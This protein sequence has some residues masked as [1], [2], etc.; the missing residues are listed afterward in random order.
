MRI[1]FCGDSIIE[2]GENKK[3]GF[4]RLLRK[5]FENIEILNAG[6]SGNTVMD[7]LRRLRKDVLRKNP[8]EVYLLIGINDVWLRKRGIGTS[9]NNF[10][11]YYNKLIDKLE[12]KG[13]KINICTLT[14]LGELEFKK[15][16]YDEILYDFIEKI[17]DISLERK[18][19]LIDVNEIFQKYYQMN[20]VE[21]K[22]HYRSGLYCG[23]LTKDGVHLNEDGN[24]LLG[25][26][27]IESIKFG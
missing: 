9:L 17:K 5:E 18:L 2:L 27:F 4:M 7:L 14:V 8:N 20:E 1:I 16:L 24:K 22:K 26:I 19:R 15:N 23:A 13:I 3:I 12:K 6:K 25:E 11:I 21:L 10:E